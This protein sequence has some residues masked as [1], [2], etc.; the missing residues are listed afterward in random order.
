MIILKVGQTLIVKK[1]MPCRRETNRR[2]ATVSEGHEIV[3]LEPVP[4]SGYVHFSVKNQD[5]HEA[6][7]TFEDTIERCC[8]PMKRPKPE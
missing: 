2:H 5:S 4:G 8:A 7:R 6:F 3:I 1:A